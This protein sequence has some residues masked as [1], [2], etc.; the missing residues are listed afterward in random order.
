MKSGP[1][2]WLGHALIWVNL[3][4]YTAILFTLIFECSPIEKVWNPL[5]EGGHCINRNTALIV[6][7]AVNVLSDLLNLLLPLWATWH[8]QMTWKRKA[9]I[10]AVFATGLMYGFFPLP[11]IIHHGYWLIEYS[12]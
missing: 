5:Y 7:G 10:S 1:M 11:C 6:S 12:A 2:Y 4:L 9:G 3:A 8:L